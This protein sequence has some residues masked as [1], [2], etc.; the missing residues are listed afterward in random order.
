MFRNFLFGVPRSELGSSRKMS[1]NERCHHGQLAKNLV[2]DPVE[3]S[4]GAQNVE[5]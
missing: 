5:E 1:Y 4:L 3:W 2:V